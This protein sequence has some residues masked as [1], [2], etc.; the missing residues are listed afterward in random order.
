MC[1]LGC[2]SNLVVVGF[3]RENI[4]SCSGKNRGSSLPPSQSPPPSPS[5]PCPVAS[6]LREKHCIQMK[7][8]VTSLQKVV[9]RALER[10]AVL[11]LTLF[12]HGPPSLCIMHLLLPPGL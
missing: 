8:S 12:L 5:F 7:A 2:L 9:S 1:M 10:S 11:Q 4:P 3:L 6:R